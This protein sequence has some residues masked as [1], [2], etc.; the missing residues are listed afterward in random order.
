MVTEN[1]VSSSPPLNGCANLGKYLNLSESQFL[2]G[3]I[4]IMK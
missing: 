2:I 3:Y 4:G 1:V